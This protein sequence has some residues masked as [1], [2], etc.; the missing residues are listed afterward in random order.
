M[1]QINVVGGGLAGLV[2]AIS[3]AEAGETVVLQEAHRHLGGRART[4][5]A[6]FR[7]NL[8]PHVVYS[9]GA[10][11]KWLKERDLVPRSKRSPWFGLR[12][13][14]D[15]RVRRLPPRAAVRAVLGLRGQRAP[16]DVD[17]RTWA[18]DHCGAKAAELLV[19]AAGVITFD[20]DPG[21]L[22]AA[23]VV[24]RGGRVLTPPPSNRYV[25]GGWGSLVE[26]L[27]ARARELG[28]EIRTASRM[29]ELPEPPVIVA[30][31]VQDARE[32]LDDPNL[33]VETTRCLILDLGIE[34]RR[35]D[36]FIVSDLDGG[37]WLERYSHADSTL[38]PKGHDLIQ[39]HIGMRPGE[40]AET[41]EERLGGVADAAFAGWRDRLVWHRRQVMD[42]MTGALD[43]PGQTWRD[44]PS[45]NRGDGVFV[46]GDWVAAPGLL[47]EVAFSSAVEAARA[48]REA[49]LPPAWQTA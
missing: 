39:G 20:H 23:F 43:L 46:A 24:E 49:V 13:F 11:W 18:T 2:A 48:A 37:G 1:K 47:S 9:D 41:A 25:V 35:G 42:G 7:A 33:N 36:P 22:S 12:F 16:V 3:C 5:D 27:E 14:V 45:V 10:G 8:G 21:R 38:A 44:R 30:T 6:D 29:S 26:G 34:S 15:G 32:L 17:F 31:A 4:R 40:S 28:V 19:R